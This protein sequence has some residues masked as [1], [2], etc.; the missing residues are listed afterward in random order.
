MVSA[1]AINREVLTQTW[2]DYECIIRHFFPSLKLLVVLVDDA[3][4]I[5]HVWD[6][7]NNDFGGYEGDWGE[8]PPRWEFTR[9]STGPFTIV[10]NA[11]MR[12]KE[13]IQM[14]MKRRFERE[15][16]D[17]KQYTTP[18]LYIMGCWLPP[19]IEIPEC[20]RW[21]DDWTGWVRTQG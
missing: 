1:L 21:P 18:A 13:Y 14:Q 5:E 2:D 10:S 11:N 20:G 15:E 6:V 17:Y 16:E 3:I 9:E 4:A 7:K 8:F 12:Y 19:G